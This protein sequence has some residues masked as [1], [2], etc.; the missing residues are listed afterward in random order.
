MR[1]DIVYNEDCL[2]GMKRLLDE[3]I[4]LIYSD[5][6][7]QDTDFF[8]LKDCLRVLKNTGSLYIQCDYRNV[9]QLKLKLDEHL[10]FRNWIIW[11]YKG[12]P[13]H[14][15]FYQ[16][17]HDDILFYTKSEN[18]IWNCP[19]TSVSMRIRQEWSK[20]AD[21]NGYI[22]KEAMLRAGQIALSKSNSGFNCLCTDERDWWVDIPVVGRGHSKE[23][24]FG[25]HQWQ[26]PLKLVERIIRASSKEGDVVLDPFIGSGTTAVVCKELG[27]HYIGFEISS[28]DCETAR[29]RLSAIQLELI[30]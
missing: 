6:L 7:Y 10:I 3:S 16:R 28:K 29:K 18:Y 13:R 2:I 11:C 26:K 23:T 8:W 12:V 9:A 1:L 4:D 25:K 27:R 22:S 17:N 20:H 15:K 24:K 30:K 21:K 5:I 19:K 14:N